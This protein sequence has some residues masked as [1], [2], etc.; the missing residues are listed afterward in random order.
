MIDADRQELGIGREQ[1]ETPNE[2]DYH[3][4]RVILNNR[5]PYIIIYKL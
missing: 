4:D 3:D 2:S 5:K 1:T